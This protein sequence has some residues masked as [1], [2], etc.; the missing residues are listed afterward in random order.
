MKAHGQGV[1]E[2][3]LGQ[4]DYNILSTLKLN[5]FE[6]NEIVSDTWLRAYRAPFP[7]PGHT[8]GAVGWAR[9]FSEGRH[10]FDVPDEAVRATLAEK[11]AIAIWGLADRTLRAEH[12]LPLFES[13][14]P[15]APVHCL[16]GVG[17]YSPEDAP[18]TI[19][20][21]IDAFVGPA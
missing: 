15:S 7:T 1:L 9:G 2:Q 8:L 6:R 3:V 13:A 16:P 10:R 14:F 12:F 5:G 20:K 18:D 17:H 4:L 11:P 21:L 19:A